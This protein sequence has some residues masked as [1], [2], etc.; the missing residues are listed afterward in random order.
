M[1]P[2][3]AAES[4]PSTQAG[5]ALTD[6]QVW[7]T[8]KSALEGGVGIVNIVSRDFWGTSECSP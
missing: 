1:V 8:V 6:L 4:A 3:A 5:A 2:A 7:K